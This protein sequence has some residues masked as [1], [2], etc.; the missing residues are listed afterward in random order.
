MDNWFIVLNCFKP[1]VIKIILSVYG[2]ILVM[3][4]VAQML[5]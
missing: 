2:C 5:A 4:M 3:V 1:C